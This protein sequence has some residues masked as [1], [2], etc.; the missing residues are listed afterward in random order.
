MKDAKAI[1]KS[2]VYIQIFKTV[3][4]RFVTQ[5]RRHINKTLG[6]LK[7]PLRCFYLRSVLW[8]S[9]GHTG[10]TCLLPQI[11]I[12]QLLPDTGL[13]MLTETTVHLID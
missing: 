7:A 11:C 4:K 10:Q 13:P 5:P 9:L 8:I 3:A 12:S 1:N 2:L 6:A